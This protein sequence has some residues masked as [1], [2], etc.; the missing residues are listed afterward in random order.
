MVVVLLLHDDDV[1]MMVYYI[2]ATSSPVGHISAGNLD[3]DIYLEVTNLPRQNRRRYTTCLA[4]NT[5]N[6]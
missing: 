2:V 4:L 6:F 5:V 3:A 1:V